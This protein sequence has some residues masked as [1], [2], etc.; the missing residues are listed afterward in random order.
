[1]IQYSPLPESH[2]LYLY[3]REITINCHVHYSFHLSVILTYS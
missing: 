3:Q 1:M 2:V